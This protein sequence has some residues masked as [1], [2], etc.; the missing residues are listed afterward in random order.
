VRVALIS[1]LDQ[2]EGAEPPGLQTFA[3]RSIARHQVDTALALGCERIVCVADGAGPAVVALQRAAER[4][5]AQFNAVGHHRAL[6][7]LARAVDEV[8]VFTPGLI[9]DTAAIAAALDARPGIV[10][11]PAER[12]VAEGFERIDRDGAWAGVLLVRGD[13][14]EGLTD[15][16]PGSDPIAGLLRVALQRGVRRVEL[17]PALLDEGR[18]AL[19]ASGEALAKI[20]QGWLARRVPRPDPLAPQRFLAAMV[21]RK[22]A[23]KALERNRPAMPFAAG[24]M[25][26]ALGA[27][28]LGMAGLPVAGLLVLAGASFVGAVAQTI[29]RIRPSRTGRNISSFTVQLLLDLALPAIALGGPGARDWPPPFAAAVLVLARRLLERRSA[30]W[31]LLAS[32]R[33]V[34]AIILTA[35]AAF[36][37]LTGAVAIVALAMLFASV[38]FAEKSSANAGLT[39]AR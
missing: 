7:G 23:P 2:R 11:L 31:T 24:A 37:A 6:A 22:L 5:G 15:L 9:P 35:A 10:E 28:A 18:W 3:G 33:L 1:V 38:F 25:L 21:A 14:I 19:P 29:S 17:P 27:A 32:D 34:L 8:L 30:R 12:G 39:T 4:A 36:G 16:P 26:G 20:E 13:A